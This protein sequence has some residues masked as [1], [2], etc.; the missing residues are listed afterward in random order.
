MVCGR[1]IRER[2]AVERWLDGEKHLVGVVAWRW[3]R[4]ASGATTFPRVEQFFT[5]WRGREE[6]H[7]VA[8]L[9]LPAMVDDKA[10]A[11]RM[12]AAIRGHPE[13]LD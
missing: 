2:E 13:R 12:M 4:S 3:L 11:E 7:W 9:F 8:G 5:R 6:C 10:D 1:I